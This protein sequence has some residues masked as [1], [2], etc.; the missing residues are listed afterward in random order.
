MKSVFDRL[1]NLFP[2]KELANTEPNMHLN[3]CWKMTL[4]CRHELALKSTWKCLITG[5]FLVILTR[6]F[7]TEPT[8][9]LEFFKIFLLCVLGGY[10]HLVAAGGRRCPQVSSSPEGR[11]G[12]AMGP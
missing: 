6:F 4:L 1:S 12:T 3:R 11:G 8:E 9:Y 7:V 2:V 10:L 5:Q